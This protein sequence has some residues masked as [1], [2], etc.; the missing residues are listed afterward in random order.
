MK[1]T[2][3]KSPI[4]RPTA[5]K[6]LGLPFIRDHIKKMSLETTPKEDFCI[7]IPA[8]VTSKDVPK[9]KSKETPRDVNQKQ[10]VINS[11]AKKSSSPKNEN[12]LL[13]KNLSE[14]RDPINSQKMREI[15]EKQK[16]KE[17]ERE[18]EKEKEKEDKK[19][20]YLLWYILL[21]L[22]LEKSMPN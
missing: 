6:I 14:E 3:D 4:N 12:P 2:L 1:T 21:N 9:E 7:D 5:R 13:Q 18:K 15:I 16:G 19:N 8:L 22:L 10:T 11:K 17:K 20:R